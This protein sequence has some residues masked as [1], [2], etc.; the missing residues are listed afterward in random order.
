MSG[1]GG[2]GSPKINKPRTVISTTVFPSPVPPTKA[3]GHFPLGAGLGSGV[4]PQKTEPL[5]GSLLGPCR[6]GLPSPRF[7]SELGR[8]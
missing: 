2:G 7:L 1:G 8:K 5:G 6:S 3:L 4:V